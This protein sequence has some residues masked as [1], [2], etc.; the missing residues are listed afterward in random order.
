[1]KTCL[2]SVGISKEIQVK[3]NEDIEDVVNETLRSIPEEWEVE[4]LTTTDYEN[5]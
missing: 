4:H 2:L 5:S 3:D 1:M